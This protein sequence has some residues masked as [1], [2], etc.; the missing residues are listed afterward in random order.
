MKPLDKALEIIGGPAKL[1]AALGVTV[2]AVC[3][4]REERRRLPADHCPTIERI[5]GVRCEALRPDV[6]WAVLRR[7]A[8]PVK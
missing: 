7:T 3:F 4:W 8:E 6:D 2:Q 1:A 5:T